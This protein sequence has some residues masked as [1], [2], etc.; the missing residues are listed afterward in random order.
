MRDRKCGATL[1]ASEGARRLCREIAAR[2]PPRKG[3]LNAR[4]SLSD[5]ELLRSV[6]SPERLRARPHRAT[7]GRREYGSI[8]SSSRLRPWPHACWSGRC[9]LTRLG[10]RGR[11]EWSEIWLKSRGLLRV[12]PNH[13]V[14]FPR[15]QTQDHFQGRGSMLP[16]WFRRNASWPTMARCCVPTPCFPIARTFACQH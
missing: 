3:W 1:S 16:R 14:F 7:V 11:A 12:M 10:N 2:S 6:Q 9:S 8:G 15:L 4:S 5:H 13:I